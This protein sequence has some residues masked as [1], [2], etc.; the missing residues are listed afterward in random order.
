MLRQADFSALFFSTSL[1]QSVSLR[2]FVDAPASLVDAIA[3]FVG[4]VLRQ[5]DDGLCQRNKHDSFRNNMHRL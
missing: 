4:A 5:P 3:E 2:D 1:Q